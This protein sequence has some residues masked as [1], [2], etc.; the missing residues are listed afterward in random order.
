MTSPHRVINPKELAPAH[1]FSHVVVPATGRTIYLGGQ[2]A[3][4][5]AGRLSGTTVVEQFDAAAGNVVTALNEVDAGPEDI[6]SMQIFV[7]DAA[8]YRESLDELGG[9]YRS[10][11]G[12]HYP[13]I[14]L[15]EVGSLFDP[16]ALIELVC[17][18]V[19]PTEERHYRAIPPEGFAP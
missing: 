5:P 9:V 6:V 12:R 14:A 17:I 2:T 18:A 4:D 11:F 13:A 15:F 3:H 16:G 1:G 10:H 8:A 7:T 19:V